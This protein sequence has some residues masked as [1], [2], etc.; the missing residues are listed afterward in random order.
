MESA[1][2]AKIGLSK[3]DVWLKR[4]VFHGILHGLSLMWWF[5]VIFDL[6]FMRFYIAYTNFDGPGS[7]IPDSFTMR[8]FDTVF[9]K[10][11]HQSFAEI[12]RHV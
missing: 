2:S 3:S 11:M 6:Y 8:V 5:L 7:S 10:W 1:T 12:A 9:K 4:L